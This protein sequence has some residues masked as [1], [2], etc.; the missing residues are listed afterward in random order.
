MCEPRKPPA[1]EVSANGHKGTGN[2]GTSLLTSVVL[3]RVPVPDPG[4][5][6]ARPWGRAH[7]V[8]FSS[9]LQ[10]HSSEAS[11]LTMWDPLTEGGVQWVP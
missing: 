1:Q 2:R 5:V 4:A 10:H 8:P 11:M 7:R 3:S 6:K 9:L